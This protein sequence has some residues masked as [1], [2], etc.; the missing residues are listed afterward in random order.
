MKYLIILIVIIFP[1]FLLS[2]TFQRDINPFSVVISED[3]LQAPFIGGFN[4][5]N[6]RFLD[7][8]QDGLIDL[9]IRDEDGFLQYFKN[10]GST[11][12]P[13][14]QLQT[15]A[16]Q[17][18]YVSMW[19]SFMDFENDGDLDLLCQTSGTYYISAYEN[20][21]GEFQL[22]T[23]AL[24]DTLGAPVYGSEANI[25]TLADIDGDDLEDFF[26][27]DQMGSGRVIYYSNVGTS[28]G[29][30]LFKYIT[31]YFQHILLDWDPSGINS[32]HGAN[33]LEFFDVDGNNTKDLFWGALVQPG[34]FFLENIGTPQVPDIPDSLMITSY[35]E[36]F[37]VLTAGFN[38]PRFADID[39]DGDSELFLGVQSGQYGTDNID[40][41]WYYL[42]NG[43]I[44]NPQFTFVTKN[45]ISTLNLYSNSVPTFID[46]DNDNDLDLFIGNELD[47]PTSNGTVYLFENTGDSNNPSF[48]LEDNSYFGD[49][50]GNNLAPT[51]A[52]ID[53]DGDQDGFVGDWNGKIFYFEN[54][55]NSS[56]PNFTNSVEFLDIDLSG[57]STPIFGDIDQDIDLDFFIGD[58]NGKIHYWEN[59]GS[60]TNPDFRSENADYFPEFDL[61]E[62]IIISLYDYENDG[63]L[64]FFI[65]ND[66]GQLFLIKNNIGNFECEELTNF[67]YSGI[68]IAP[69]VVD[70]DSDG[71]PELFI[72]S[73]T[74]GLQ[75]FEMDEE[76]SIHSQIIIPG[77]IILHGNYPNP[78]NPSTTIKLELT[79]DDFV[80]L[81]I[82]DLRGRMV[83]QLIHSDLETG[84]WKVTW[85]GTDDSGKMVSA[86]IYLCVLKSDTYA[87]T[88]KMILLK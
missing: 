30:P 78:F 59:E 73:R 46:I 4:K 13:E 68:N 17:E 88:K 25:P 66:T 5:P 39:S 15:K 26:V 57:Y 16:F 1:I 6:P 50:L 48:T 11:L 81:V 40:N 61:G 79:K 31:N 35:P 29:L 9:F 60:T 8:D 20:I 41:F 12:S 62:N 18:L 44:S 42:N 21:S 82:Y 2:Q 85:N 33:S 80:R 7:W 43:T 52:D 22:R 87:Q 14:F 36:E 37:P 19:F 65:G 76:L 69:A 75:Y 27:G 63:D 55:G 77:Q 54:I 47:P 74:G 32:R 45:F 64:D 24:L 34:L 72:G 53:G 70:I 67:P 51:F 38:A 84:E 23:E 58:I 49:S 10:V 83:K 71:K 3:I 56:Q 28:N 86:G